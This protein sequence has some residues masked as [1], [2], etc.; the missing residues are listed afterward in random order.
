MHPNPEYQDLE[1]D[2]QR[3]NTLIRCDWTCCACG[4]KTQKLDVHH[5][6]YTKNQPIWVVEPGQLIALCKP[7]HKKT[8]EFK[9]QLAMFA[10]MPAFRAVIE[11]IFTLM[12]TSQSS[13]MLTALHKIISRV[14]QGE[15]A[16]D[17]AEQAQ[18][19]PVNS[20]NGHERTA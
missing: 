14:C 12:H 1:W 19:E 3:V 16:R 6:Y 2:K 15:I 10:H 7:C 8:K 9:D 5:R 11:S 4:E 18:N 17:L 20:W 13:E